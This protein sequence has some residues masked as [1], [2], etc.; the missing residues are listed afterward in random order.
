MKKG[1]GDMAQGVQRQHCFIKTL[2]RTLNC[3]EFDEIEVKRQKK[4]PLRVLGLN[5]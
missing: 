5:M 2:T 4:K 3:P 1:S